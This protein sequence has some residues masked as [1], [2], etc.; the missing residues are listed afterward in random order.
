MELVFLKA[1]V[2]S[3]AVSAALAITSLAMLIL[4]SCAS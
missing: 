1:L 2:F 3:F 4:T